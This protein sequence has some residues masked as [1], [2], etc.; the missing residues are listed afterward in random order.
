LTKIQIKED[1]NW[2]TIWGEDN[3]A[4]TT[5]TSENYNNWLPTLVT[6]VPSQTIL[7]YAGTG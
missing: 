7:S 4:K 1:G 2:V 6:Q 3:T 5:Y